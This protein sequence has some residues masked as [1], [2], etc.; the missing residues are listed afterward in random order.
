[1]RPF[2]LLI[3]LVPLLSACRTEFTGAPHFPNGVDGCRAT[4][5][6]DGLEMSGFVYS[7]EFAS[8]CVCRPKATGGWPTAYPP[9]P[10]APPPPASQKTRPNDDDRAALD[11][12]DASAAI[13]VVMQQRRAQ[14]QQQDN[15]RR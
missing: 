3:V 11:A 2:L 6:Q 10:G 4:C 8:S 9:A 1:M 7:G 15:Q 12:A 14:K 5:A 13:G